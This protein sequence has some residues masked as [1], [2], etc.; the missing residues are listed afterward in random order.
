MVFVSTKAVLMFYAN[1]T[2]L[3]GVNK[4]VPAVGIA[5]ALNA[6]RNIFMTNNTG[7]GVGNEWLK[8]KPETGLLAG[9]VS[10]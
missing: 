8:G 2:E 9:A 5:V 1:A 10:W 3:L 7:V 4:P 6:G